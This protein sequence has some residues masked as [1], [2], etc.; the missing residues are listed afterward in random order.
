MAKIIIFFIFIIFII[1]FPLVGGGNNYK[2]FLQKNTMKPTIEIFNGIFKKYNKILEINGSFIK[3]D[4]F[5]NYYK[6]N[7]LYADDLLNEEY[8][9]AKWALKKENIIK[10]KKVKYINND[11][12][13]NS[14]NII[15]YENKKFLKGWDFNFSSVKAKGRG[16]YFEVDKNKNLFAKNVV[17]FIKVE[18]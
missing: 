9:F 13:L 2:T 3:A 18:K 15:Y 11:Y 6:L 1:V 17:Y 12:S 4:F 5:K 8:Y 14:E 10:A 16:D 7:N